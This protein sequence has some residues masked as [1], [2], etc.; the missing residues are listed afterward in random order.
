MTQTTPRDVVAEYFAGFRAGDRQRILTT[1][2]DDVE[3]VIHG[4]RTARGKAEFR[5]EIENPAFT[6]KADL[7]VQRVHEDDGV[8]VTTGEGSGVSVEHGPVRFAF[9]NVFSFRDGLIARV[10]VYVVP[11]GVVV[12]LPTSDGPTRTPAGPLA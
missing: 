5:V 8:V 10:D 1:L 7:D 4:Q 3:W 2:T 11:I 9:N 12:P 6:G